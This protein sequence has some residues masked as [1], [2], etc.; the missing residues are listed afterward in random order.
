MGS[1]R[2]D[3]SFKLKEQKKVGSERHRERGKRGERW[4]GS[5]GGR[6]GNTILT[7]C[8]TLKGNSTTGSVQRH[9]CSVWD[10]GQRRSVILY[11]QYCL[12]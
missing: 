5:N 6:E 2:K 1:Y 8:R 12:V 3:L 10:P 9:V 11:P 4:G 7:T